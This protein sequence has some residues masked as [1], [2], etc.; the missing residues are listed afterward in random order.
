[1]PASL[2]DYAGMLRKLLPRGIIWEAGPQSSMGR[3]FSACAAELLRVEGDAERLGRELTP[4]TSVEALED[5]EHELGLPDECLTADQSLAARR[6]A[7]VRKLQRGGF[8]NRAYY[9]SL[10]RALGYAEAEAFSVL[11]LRAGASRAGDPVC[12]GDYPH[13]LFIAVSRRGEIRR[14]HAG[15]SQAGERLSTAADPMVEC[16]IN[17]EKPAHVQVEFQYLED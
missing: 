5:W 11:P 16:V 10:L 14:F 9:Q 2:S 3:L 8:M 15:T 7:V 17:R 13:I 12:D 1:M 4:Q 6:E